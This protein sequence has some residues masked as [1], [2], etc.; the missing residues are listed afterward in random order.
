MFW[1]FDIG[2]QYFVVQSNY[3]SLLNS[4]STYS[5]SCCSSIF[6]LAIRKVQHKIRKAGWGLCLNTH[7]TTF[8]APV[9]KLAV[10]FQVQNTN[11][12]PSGRDKL[13]WRVDLASL[14]NE[15]CC[16]GLVNFLKSSKCQHR[17]LLFCCF[18]LK[19]THITHQI[20][21]RSMPLYVN[22]Q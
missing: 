4:S 9:L 14:F 6:T 17:S 5:S 21:L 22:S 8:Y 7:F 11:K 15:F 18:L 2:E 19:P 16:F 1:T 20:K 13:L 3:R 10:L 12:N